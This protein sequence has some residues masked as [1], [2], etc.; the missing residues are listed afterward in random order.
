MLTIGG[1]AAISAPGRVTRSSVA[2]RHADADRR[3]DLS[4]RH[5][6]EAA[7]KDLGEVGRRVEREADN[8]GRRRAQ[9][10]PDIRSAGIEQ[11]QLHQERRAAQHFDVAR[12]NQRSG[13]TEAV[14][15]RDEK[16]DDEPD[17]PAE[18]PAQHGDAETADELGRVPPE[19]V[20]IH[21]APSGELRSASAPRPARQRLIAR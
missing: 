12:S 5:G 8:A 10:E 11:E 4:D 14:K 18:A 9:L 17:R 7:A 6:G 13:G 15:Q 3:L 21:R 2:R 20:K 16:A 1:M 19:D